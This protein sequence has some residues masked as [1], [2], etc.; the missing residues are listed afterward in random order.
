MNLFTRTL[1]VS[2]EY[3]LEGIAVAIELGQ[4]VSKVLGFDVPTWTTLFGGP[5]GSITYSARTDSMVSHG[6]NMAKL[7][8]DPGMQAL[9]AKAQGKLIGPVL[10]S[11][12]SF[13]AVAGE[14]KTDGKFAAVV[15]A[16]VAGGQVAA[17]MGWAVD[18]LNHVAATSG[19]GGSLVR[20]LYGPFGTLSWI[21]QFDSFEQLD[22]YD[23][24]QSADMAYV[25]KLDEGGH[26]F[27][28]GSGVTLLL[29]RLS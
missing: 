14:P 26:L 3:P 25:Q 20:N 28:P 12:S 13:V 6:A 5:Q 10:D 19:V 23:A 11:M 1:T 8:A 21:A 7:E 16:Q 15:S 18:I 29:Q 24:A 22:A 2:P 4:H 27:T 9:V 17:S